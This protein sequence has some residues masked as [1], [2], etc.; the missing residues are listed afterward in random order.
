MPVAKVCTATGAQLLADTVAEMMLRVAKEQCASPVRASVSPR[1]QTPV[2]T[3]IS[4]GIVARTLTPTLGTTG[5]PAELLYSQKSLSQLG[6]VGM[7]AAH[8]LS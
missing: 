8:N 6:R 1:E 5:R 2:L 3:G 4:P 7:F